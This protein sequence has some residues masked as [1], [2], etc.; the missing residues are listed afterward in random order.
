MGIVYEDEGSSTTPKITYEERRKGAPLGTPVAGERMKHASDSFLANL[1]DFPASVQEFATGGTGIL[2]GV[3]NLPSRIGMGEPAGDVMFPKAGDP[4]SG[5]K[6]AGQLADPV[7][8]AIGGGV[9]AASAKVLQKLITLGPAAQKV[10]TTLASNWMSRAAGRAV[11]GGVTGGTI[12][13]LSDE[14]NAETGAMIGGAANVLVPPA[15]SGVM[16]GAGALKNAVYPSAG[17]LAVRAAGDKADD[18]IAALQNARSG[19]SGL[20]LT[21]GQAAVPANSAEFSA[22]QKLA[23]SKDPSRFY[24][25]QGVQGQQE[26]ARR[27]A[28]QTIGKTP[29]DLA[30]AEASRSAASRANYTL[31]YQQAVKG[32]PELM[33]LASNPFFRDELPE[34]MRLAQANGIN[35]KQNLTQF[36]QFVKEGID[37]KIQ[38]ATKPD[39]PAL[40]KATKAALTDAKNKLVTWLGKKNPSYDFARTEHARLST[41]IDQMKLGQEIEGALRAPV[42]DAERVASFG[43]AVRKAETKISKATGQPRAAALTPGQHRTIEAIEENL[44][45][46]ADFKKLASAG[47]SNL[48][49]RIGAPTA[50]PTGIFQP[51]LSAMRSWLNALL[52]SGH[53]KALHRLAPLM[54]KTQNDSQQSCGQQHPN[55]EKPLILFWLIT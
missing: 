5:W 25:Q 21:P 6:I 30:A 49:N 41:P 15:V 16:R 50:P 36:L 4:E 55:N 37:A 1:P 39:A 8:W 26:A 38:G 46:D 44:K 12:G 3:A 11:V 18:V 2:R 24:G 17:G 35:P 22:L 7:A 31:A 28:V 54:E 51:M 47:A 27:A 45:L 48:E 14:G 43:A 13:A 10:A 42:T 23:Q 53:E 20:E 33:R 29:Q 52:G 19:V 34:A 40:S 32:D 9:P